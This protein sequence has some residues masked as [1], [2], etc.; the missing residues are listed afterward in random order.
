MQASRYQKGQSQPSFSTAI[1]LA[2]AL[3]VS[4][5]VLA[6]GDEI[7]EPQSFRNKEL[8]RRMRELDELPR[9]RQ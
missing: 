7:P 4:L 9:E 6:G 8:L 2:N 3:E 5:D 1:R